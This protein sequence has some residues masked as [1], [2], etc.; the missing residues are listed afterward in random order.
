MPPWWEVN[1]ETAEADYRQENNRPYG[2]LPCHLC[3]DPRRPAV[4]FMP[5]PLH[6]RRGPNNYPALP[7]CR[8]CSGYLCVLLLHPVL[9]RGKGQG[10]NMLGL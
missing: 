9:N 1:R 3:P 2:P 4:G 6:M 10:P 7:L 8:D 5:L